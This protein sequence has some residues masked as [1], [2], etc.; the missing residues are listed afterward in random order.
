MVILTNKQREFE[1]AMSLISSGCLVSS[2]VQGT[3]NPRFTAY[4]LSRRQMQF[5]NLS[6]NGITRYIYR[7]GYL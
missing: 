2:Y 7:R 3:R 6:A 1:A 5:S 4:S